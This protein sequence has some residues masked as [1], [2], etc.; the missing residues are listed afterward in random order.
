MK[1]QKKYAALKQAAAAFL[2][3]YGLI[4]LL[5][6]GVYAVARHK[7]GPKTPTASPESAPR[8]AVSASPAPESEADPKDPPGFLEKAPEKSSAQQSTDVFTLYDSD[9]E[10]T[11]TLTAEELLPAAVACEMDLSAPEEALKAQAVACYTLFSEKRASGETI[12][13][14]SGRWQTWTTEELMRDRW[15]EDYEE[16][17]AL[18]KKVTDSVAGQLLTYDGKPLLAAYFA[19]SAGCTETSANVWGGELPYLQT[20]ASP[21]DLFADGYLSTVRLTEEEFRA[22]VS[23]F[24][25]EDAPDL[26]GPAEQWLTG[27]TRTPAGYVDTAN[28]GGK[29]VTGREVREIFS[30]RSAAFELDASPEGFCFTVRGWGHGVGMSQA[31]AA[32]LAKQ[33]ADYQEIL[34]YYYPGAA[35]A[36]PT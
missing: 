31:G 17:A 20:V 25:P 8:P 6:S 15:G 5:P 7:E 9:T 30:L 19:I 16:N 29:E 26:S 23:A 14:A 32:F 27:I 18:L 35:L 4:A 2:V 36:F 13:C 1:E 24:Y 3:I 28:L 33:G 21:G 10:E 11:L 34:E 12:S 22:A